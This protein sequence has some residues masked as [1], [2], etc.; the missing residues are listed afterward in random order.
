MIKSFTQRKTISLR[1]L[2]F[3][4]SIGIAQVHVEKFAIKI[5]WKK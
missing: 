4:E 3:A 2:N 5:Q 1:C